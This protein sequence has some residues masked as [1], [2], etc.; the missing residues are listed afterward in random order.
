MPNEKVAFDQGEGITFTIAIRHS[1]TTDSA[2]VETFEPDGEQSSL[3]D[4]T[5]IRSGNFF[6]RAVLPRWSRTLDAN[7]ERGRWLYRVTYYSGTYG[8]TIVEKDFWV[9]QNCQANI[10]HANPLNSNAYYQASNTISSSSVISNGVHIVYDAENVT[11]LTTGFRA[12]VGSK[13]EVK[14][15]GCN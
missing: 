4:L 1:L 6:S 13:L 11:T 12:P 3:I 14:T 7:A 10:V 5:Y 2:I 8:V 15:A 9:A